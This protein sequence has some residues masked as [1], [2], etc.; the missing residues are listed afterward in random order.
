MFI[1]MHKGV[2]FDDRW[3]STMQVD[4]FLTLPMSVESFDLPEDLKTAI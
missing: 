1:N 2:V 3:L 4:G